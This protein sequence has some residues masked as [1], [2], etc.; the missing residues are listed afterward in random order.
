VKG[1][2]C[3]V[4]VA[5]I[6]PRRE[7]PEADLAAT[8]ELIDF[9]CAAGVDGISLMGSTGEF[10]HFELEERMRLVGLAI[11][12]SRVPVLAGVAHSTF[13]G[14]VALARS[15]SDAGAAALLIMPPYFFRYGQEEIREFYLSF[16][17]ELKDG[18]PLVI[19]NLPAFSSGIE[20]ATA[21]DLLSTGL[22]AGIKDSSGSWD[23]FLLLK[24]V[25]EKQ[26]FTLL[27]GNDRVYTQARQA[28]ADG[29]VSGCAC[30]VPEL[31]LAIERAIEAGN[32][33]AAA[34]LDARLKEF[35]AW[36][37]RF[38]VPVG[39]R[40]AVGLRAIKTGPNAIPLGAEGQARLT[41][42]REWFRGWLP[43]VIEECRHAQ[44]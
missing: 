32:S 30:A 2:A 43:V 20:A 40:E 44:A 28:G 29:A 15:A 31:L 10:L 13:D 18:A 3:G 7:G 16:A 1:A 21:V 19:Y 37:E 26:R 9:L 22:F 34:R 39:V 14:A 12:R 5:A 8:F 25:R 41:E 17:R 6:T 35:I 38:P 24:A 4:T 27:I 42:F 36:I 23:D 11:K 33:P